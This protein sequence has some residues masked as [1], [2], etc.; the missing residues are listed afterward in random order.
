MFVV[1][2]GIDG[3]G[4]STQID[5]LR[6]KVEA[7]G[8]VVCS[9][10][11]PGG[12][13][14]GERVRSLVLEATEVPIS[15]RTETLLYMASRAQLV[16]EVIGPALERGEVVISDR[17]LS[18]NIAYQGHGGGLDPDAVAEVGQFAV[19]GLLPD[20]ILVL[21]LDAAEA[22]RRL[23]RDLDRIESRDEAY[24]RR[25]RDGFLALQHRWPDRVVV[26]DAAGTPDEV[27]RQVWQV[28]EQR[29]AA[30]RGAVGR[31]G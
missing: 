22:R 17:Y 23:T 1:F 4:K 18:A 14:L 9:C 5:R 26:I 25:V 28:T 29:W 10:R 19:G 16:A 27:H 15:P 12:T 6:Q 2:D 8:W 13:V 24:F 30:L 11:D 31:P 3:T 7:L 20:L 21:D